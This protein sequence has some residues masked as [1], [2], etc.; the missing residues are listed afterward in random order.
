MEDSLNLRDRNSDSQKCTFCAKNVIRKLSR[1]ISSHF[2]QFTL[3]MSDAAG[4]R[5]KIH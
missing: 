3:E 5:Q 4:S 2:V 1:S